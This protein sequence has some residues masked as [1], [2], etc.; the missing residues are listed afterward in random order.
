MTTFPWLSINHYLLLQ[1]SSNNIY[2]N[3]CYHGHPV[4]SIYQPLIAR[5]WPVIL[6][7]KFSCA[8]RL[9]E[10]NYY[11]LVLIVAVMAAAIHI[12]HLLKGTLNGRLS[13]P[14]SVLLLQEL[15]GAAW[16]A[17]FSEKE[18][19]ESWQTMKAWRP[20]TSSFRLSIREWRLSWF[21]YSVLRVLLVFMSLK[22]SSL[23]LPS[24]E[25]REDI[26]LSKIALCL[27]AHWQIG[28]L[29]M[30]FQETHHQI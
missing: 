13:V 17:P 20:N 5:E 30:K 27:R 15:K 14:I 2:N 6:I 23:P 3:I 12:R 29:D 24:V 18:L 25:L 19:S 16:R 7:S 26:D 9:S 10:E 21:I 28:Q 22:V 1:S 4:F 8:L 11:L